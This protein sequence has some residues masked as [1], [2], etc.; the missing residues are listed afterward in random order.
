MQNLYKFPRY[1][2][3]FAKEVTNSYL[4]EMKSTIGDIDVNMIEDRTE[5]SLYYLFPL[6]ERIIVEILKY[7]PDTDIEFSEQGTYRT[8][9]SILSV[10]KNA[11]Y[12][13]NDLV[14]LIK[15]YY[16]ENGLRN[17]MMHFRG[18]DNIE[19]SFVDLLEIKVILTKLLKI[20]KLT[21]MNIEKILDKDIE[22]L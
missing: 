7:K 2:G 15:E 21:L 13:D 1:Y 12:F 17:Q 8:L 20:Y 4:P 3:Y 22:L 6:I 16:S 11:K 19:I 5:K 10:N 18:Q 14:V 9:N